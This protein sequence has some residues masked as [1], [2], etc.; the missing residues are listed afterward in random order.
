MTC[1]VIE[2]MLKDEEERIKTQ[3]TLDHIVIFMKKTVFPIERVFDIL[4]VP[5]EKQQWYREKV[6]DMPRPERNMVS[7]LDEQ[8]NR[9]DDKRC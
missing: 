3:L 1:R 5:Q 9:T 6:K 2:Q 4:E 7:W 8:G